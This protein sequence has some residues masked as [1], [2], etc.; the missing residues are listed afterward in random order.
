MYASVNMTNS[1]RDNSLEYCHMIFNGAIKQR[2]SARQK[3]DIRTTIQ[4]CFRGEVS[5]SSHPTLGRSI[6]LLS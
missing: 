1:K 3:N 4:S 5:P 2:S 6:I